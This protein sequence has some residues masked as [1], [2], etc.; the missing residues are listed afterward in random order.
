MHFVPD[1]TE[2]SILKDDICQQLEAYSYCIDSLK[3]EMQKRTECS[4]NMTKV[5]TPFH[6]IVF[7]NIWV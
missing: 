4:D 6:L 7:T 1:F 3:I 2:I 5:T